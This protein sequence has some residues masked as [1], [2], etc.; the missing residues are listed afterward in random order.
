MGKKTSV[1]YVYDTNI[2]IYFLDRNLNVDKYFSNDFFTSHEIIT[3]RIVRIELLS[4]PALTAKDRTVIEDLLGIVEL[5]PLSESLEDLSIYFRRQY[6]LKLPDAI[7]ASTAFQHSATLV[8]NN[9]KDFKKISEIKI[10]T[11]TR[12]K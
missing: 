8:T 1:K 7:I 6:K 2:F 5:I 4:Y 12:K 11:P 3:S 10:E 9:S